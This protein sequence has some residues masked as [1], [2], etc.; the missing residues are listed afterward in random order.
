MSILTDNFNII[1]LSMSNTVKLP[2]PLQFQNKIEISRTTPHK[3]TQLYSFCR[4]MFVKCKC[5]YN[6]L[7]NKHYADIIISHSWANSSFSLQLFNLKQY[8]K[9]TQEMTDFIVQC[10]VLLS[11]LG[12]FCSHI[13]SEET[14]IIAIFVYK[15]LTDM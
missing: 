8:I 11:F 12:S 13:T 3:A 4:M 10:E 1:W 14:Q 15:F 6:N 2:E 9:I 7:K 5:Q